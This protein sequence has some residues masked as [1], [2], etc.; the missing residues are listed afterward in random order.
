MR[1]FRAGMT[2]T[3]FLRVTQ[4]G[5][6]APGSVRVRATIVDERGRTR[7]D[8][9]TV[10]EGSGLARSRS[11]DYRLDLPLARLEP[12]PHLLTIEAQLGDTIVHRQAR[13]SLK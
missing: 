8:E 13:F 6:K 2:A 10:I 11:A 1:D 7:L 12:G 5:S 4:G 9:V 3:A